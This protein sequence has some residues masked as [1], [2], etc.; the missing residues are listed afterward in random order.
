[1]AGKN[2]YQSLRE[3][4]RPFKLMETGIRVIDTLYPIVEGGTGFI[5]VRLVAEKPYFSMRS[6]SKP[7]PTW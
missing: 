1:M 2:T 7:K 5:P 3:K 4:P 6:Q